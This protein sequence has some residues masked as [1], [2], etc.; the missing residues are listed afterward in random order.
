M[1][2]IMTIYINMSVINRLFL[3]TKASKMKFK[4]N[5]RQFKTSSRNRKTDIESRIHGK[6]AKERLLQE[7]EPRESQLPR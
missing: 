7:A 4:P 6:N 5:I 3:T 2:R 1:Y